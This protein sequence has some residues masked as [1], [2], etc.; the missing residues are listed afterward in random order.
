MTLTD[1]KHHEG[2]PATTKYTWPS[3][4]EDPKRF[5]ST[6]QAGGSI[7]F[8]GDMFRAKAPQ[9]TPWITENTYGHSSPNEWAG[10][11]TSKT[12][13]ST[14]SGTDMAVTTHHT[15][16]RPKSP[17]GS[18]RFGQFTLS[19]YL[20]QEDAAVEELHEVVKFVQPHIEAIV[21]SCND[22]HLH[23]PDGWITSAGFVTCSGKAGLRLS[24]DEF[25]TL[26]RSVP[27]DIMGRIN[28]LHVEAVVRAIHEANEG[29]DLNCTAPQ[30]MGDSSL[31]LTTRPLGGPGPLSTTTRR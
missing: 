13:V 28:Y 10:R 1:N 25:L 17:P 19:Q 7:T 18:I 5:E 26:E 11:I 3:A 23:A 31:L 29:N 2:H 20:P 4:T 9:A 22:Y 6:L 24:R 8:K 30:A 15:Y 12:I 16:S 14:G 27:K 21:K